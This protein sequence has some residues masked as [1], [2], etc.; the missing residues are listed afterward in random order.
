MFQKNRN[1]VVDLNNVLS[2]LRLENDLFAV[3]VVA[4]IER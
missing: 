1:V 3:A 4:G 2:N